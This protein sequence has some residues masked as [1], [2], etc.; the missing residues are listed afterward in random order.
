[1][2]YAILSNSLSF[3]FICRSSDS[4][5]DFVTSYTLHANLTR[6]LVYATRL[7]PVNFVCALFVFVFVFLLF[8]FF[9]YHLYEDLARI[10][11][12]ATRL[13]PATSQRKTSGE[14]DCGCRN[15]NPSKINA[16]I[17]K[18]KSK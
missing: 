11:A 16:E 10:L 1:M 6:I 8:L 2:T 15:A 7:L 9:D 4:V 18:Y 14:A 3:M 12:Y 5:F 17:Q 13:L